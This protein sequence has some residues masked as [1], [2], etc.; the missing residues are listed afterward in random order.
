MAITSVVYGSGLVEIGK[1]TIDWQATSPSNISVQLTQD[2]YTPDKD[3]HE[4]LADVSSSEVTGTTDQAIQGGITDP[5]HSAGTCS[6]DSTTNPTWSAV[7]PSPAETVGGVIVYYATGVESTSTLI[8]CNA[9]TGGNI[10]T[11]GSDI[12]VTWAS[13]GVFKITY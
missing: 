12:Q 3:A 11:N 2:S 4:D 5:T 13:D 8:S 9:F 10:T 6:F 1:G 7:G